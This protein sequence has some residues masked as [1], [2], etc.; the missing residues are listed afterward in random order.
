MKPVSLIDS[1]FSPRDAV[2]FL[3]LSRIDFQM[4]QSVN[5]RVDVRPPF[6]K[7]VLNEHNLPLCAHFKGIQPN[8]K[9]IVEIVA[10]SLL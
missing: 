3:Y 9:F 1:K 5:M 4:I 6:G 10:L 8:W 7:H 2:M